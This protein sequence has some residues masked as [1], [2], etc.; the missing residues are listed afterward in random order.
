MINIQQL[1]AFFKD[2]LSDFLSCDTVVWELLKSCPFLNKGYVSESLVVTTVHIHERVCVELFSEGG[3][4]G[5][6]G[7]RVSVSGTSIMSS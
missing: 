6:S 1:T 7:Y 5:L 2:C 3:T 4:Q